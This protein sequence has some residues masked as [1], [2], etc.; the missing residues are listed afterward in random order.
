MK[1]NKDY[2][3]TDTKKHGGLRKSPVTVLIPHHNAGV[4]SGE[5][6]AKYMNNTT[7]QLSATYIIGQNG[8]IFQT[9]DEKYEPYTTGNRS[10]DTKAITFEIV[11][12]KGAPTWE[13]SDEAF[14]A[15]VEL[16][17]DICKRYN[18]KE[19][20][21]TGDKKG[22]IHLHEWYANTNC[23]GPYLK[24]KMGEYAKR[25]NEG[26]NPTF[27][28][29]SFIIPKGSKLFDR[30]GKA[31]TKPTTVT[32]TVTV[33]E[34]RNGL[35]RFKA[36]W[37]QGVSEAWVDITKKGG[38]PSKPKDEYVTVGG[39]KT[40]YKAST[41]SSHYGAKV[42]SLKSRKMKVL[43]RKNGRVQVYS[44]G[45]GVFDVDSFWVVV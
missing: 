28:P 23:P 8:E 42:Q 37:L 44:K 6:V 1:I 12:S 16:S 17:I 9:L 15:L 18:I 45:V 34:E 11:N 35:G 5:N 33:V 38:S 4:A 27:K 19:L 39:R 2:L 22:N 32:H 29:Y 21:Y 36:S 3:V 10:I 31:Y 30:S 20:N 14:N 41:G 43:D 24:G 25:V 40:L 26:L 13:V 7:R